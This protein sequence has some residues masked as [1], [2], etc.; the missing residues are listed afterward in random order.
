MGIE[1]VLDKSHMVN[2]N[3]VLLPQVVHELCIINCYPF[4]TDFHIANPV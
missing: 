4:L 1:V 2:I 3:I